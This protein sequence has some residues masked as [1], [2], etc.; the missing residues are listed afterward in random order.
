MLKFRLN[1]IVTITLLINIF[2]YAMVAAKDDQ[3]TEAF[4]PYFQEAIRYQVMP[5]NALLTIYLPGKQSKI[6]SY[7]PNMGLQ[8]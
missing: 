4:F 8:L 2:S 1:H 7:Q 5:S 6:V 3:K